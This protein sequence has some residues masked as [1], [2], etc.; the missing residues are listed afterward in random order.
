MEVDGMKDST[1]RTLRTALASALALAAAA[2]AVYEAV[3]GDQAAA[4]GWLAGIV[5]LCATIT[6]VVTIPAGDRSPSRFA[7]ARRAAPRARTEG[8]P[9]TFPTGAETVTVS[10]GPILSA[11]GRDDVRGTVT[12]PPSAATTH[13]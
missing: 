4:G 6:R 2:P 11:D 9:M 13:N 12:V 1:R 5:A 7:L 10:V 3:G 8:N